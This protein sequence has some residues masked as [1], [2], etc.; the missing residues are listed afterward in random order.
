ML[1]G[2]GAA[3]EPGILTGRSTDH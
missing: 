3:G 1:S 2:A